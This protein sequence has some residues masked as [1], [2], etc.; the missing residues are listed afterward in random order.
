MSTYDDM[1]AEIRE[2]SAVS[3]ELTIHSKRRGTLKLVLVG[4]EGPFPD[5]YAELHVIEELIN[6]FPEHICRKYR[7]TP[8]EEEQ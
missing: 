8:F 3:F 1:M 6:R 7:D 4:P 5:D 2:K